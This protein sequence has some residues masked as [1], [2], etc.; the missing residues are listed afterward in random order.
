MIITI[1]LNDILA[2]KALLQ[3]GIVQE[4][5][6]AMEETAEL[7]KEISKLNREYKYTHR[8][9]HQNNFLEE[10]ADVIITSNMIAKHYDIDLEEVLPS[11]I[12]H[13]EEKIRAKLE[14]A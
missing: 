12:K 4:S 14:A 2:K 13:K 1:E 9:T 8:I 5:L 11:I 3:N 10:L 6:M 7:A